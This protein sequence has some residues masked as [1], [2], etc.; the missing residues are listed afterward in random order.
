MSSQTKNSKPFKSKLPKF[1]FLKRTPK[2]PTIQQGAGSNPS[3]P[4]CKK[5]KDLAN[6][7]EK[8]SRK[9][10]M[11]ETK[12]PVLSAKVKENTIFME[13]SETKPIITASK[14]EFWYGS[15]T[16]TP[17]SCNRIITSSSIP[18]H[19]ITSENISNNKCNNNRPRSAYIPRSNNNIKNETFA[20]C[21]SFEM[22]SMTNPG[23]DKVGEYR[24]EASG[25]DITNCKAYL[26]CN[27]HV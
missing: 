1:T 22:N 8:A 26:T 2:K 24:V 19:S 7:T 12:I 5:D 11:V 17:L 18:K 13:K 25:A 16:D 23:K 6:M 15:K 21:S 27:H 10:S 9:N 4:T 14:S 3:P 20:K